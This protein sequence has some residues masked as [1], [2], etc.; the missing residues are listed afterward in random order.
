VSPGFTSPLALRL[1]TFKVGERWE[2][3]GPALSVVPRFTADTTVFLFLRVDRAV[4]S[5]FRRA[6]EGCIIEIAFI[7]VNS[8]FLGMMPMQETF[9]KKEKFLLLRLL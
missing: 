4:I 2:A 8:S 7:K 3:L 1:T 5:S 6:W 9:K